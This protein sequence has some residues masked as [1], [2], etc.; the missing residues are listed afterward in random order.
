VCTTHVEFGYRLHQIT[1]SWSCSRASRTCY[2]LRFEA[3]SAKS[4]GNEFHVMEHAACSMIDA[5]SKWSAQLITLHNELCGAAP[6]TSATLCTV[7]FKF[8]LTIHS[9]SLQFK[10]DGRSSIQFTVHFS[11]VYSLQFKD[12]GCSSMQFRVQFSSIH[13]SQY[14]QTRSYG[15]L[16]IPC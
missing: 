13:S 8:S 5:S 12:G 10:Y 3:S 15:Y 4:F 6:S 9:S 7:S 16:E 11:L 14:R 1:V 2:G